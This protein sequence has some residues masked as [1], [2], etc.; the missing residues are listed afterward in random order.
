M[1]SLEAV[2]HVLKDAGEPLNYREITKRMLKHGLWR[3]T[4]RTPE[5]TVNRDISQE[6]K[7]LGRQSRFIRVAAGVYGLTAAAPAKAAERED[8]GP[9]PLPVSERKKAPVAQVAPASA[10]QSDLSLLVAAWPSLPSTSKEG[11]LEI[12]KRS[13][14][15]GR[16][17]DPVVA[18][19]LPDGPKAFPAEFLA[20]DVA[21]GARVELPDEPIQVAWQPDRTDVVRSHFGFIH[22]VRNATEGRFILYAHLRGHR[23]VQVP[24]KMIHVFKAVKAYEQYLRGL[25]QDLFRAYGRSC[26]NPALASRQANRAFISLGLPLDIA[27]PIK[28]DEPVNAKRRRHGQRTPESQF[29]LPILQALA[30]M[31]GSGKMAEVLE[32][33]GK[34]MKET[35]RDVDLQPLGSSPYMPRWRNTTQWARNTMVQEGLLKADSPRGV[36]EITDK[37]WQMLHPR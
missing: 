35:L 2:Y 29:Y 11:I 19:T 1:N 7:R 4:G 5:N 9:P 34:A 14:E 8:A 36:W 37:G 12:V 17:H 15:T 27:E 16:S 20:A 28:E 25:W 22:Q 3:T 30:E 10:G 32:R 21:T 13:Q 18:Q 24:D 33:V 23:A 26:G 6:I 31:G